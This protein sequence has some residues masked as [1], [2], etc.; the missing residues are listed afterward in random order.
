MCPRC[1]K[2]RRFELRHLAGEEYDYRF[3]RKRRLA[4][5]ACVVCGHTKK[6]WDN[7]PTIDLNANTTSDFYKKT[8]TGYRKL[9]LTF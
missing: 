2:R 9:A 3:G 7:A 4:W 6:M 5:W 8:P 1:E